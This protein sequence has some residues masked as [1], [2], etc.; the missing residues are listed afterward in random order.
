[1]L[2]HLPRLLLALLLANPLFPAGT[3]IV[4]RAAMG[5]AVSLAGTRVALAQRSSGG[6][7]RP[8]TG[9]SSSYSRP[10]T[11]T[12]SGSSSGG[13]AAPRRPSTQPSYAPA[14]S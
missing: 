11:S 12:Y 9:G 10:S 6:Y 14:P 2:R 5:V 13:Y 3:G 4:V 1:M 8:S 7:S